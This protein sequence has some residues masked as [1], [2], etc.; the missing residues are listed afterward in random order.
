[1][2]R[3]S[4]QEMLAGVAQHAAHFA[5]TQGRRL[6]ES[7]DEW[8]TYM[9]HIPIEAANLPAALEL[10]RKLSAPLADVEA[11]H[12]AEAAVSHRGNQFYRWPLFCNQ[13]TRHG[14][15]VLPPQ[16]QS[17]CEGEPWRAS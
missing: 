6:V 9:V 4:E 5:T 15:C 7:P 12:V 2:T 17:D 8:G 10:A 14:G 3:P 13:A 11:A 16:H 1:M